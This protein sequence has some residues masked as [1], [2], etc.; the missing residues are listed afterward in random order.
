MS[1]IPEDKIFPRAKWSLFN[2]SKP[3][4]KQDEQELI[5]LWEKGMSLDHCAIKLGRTRLAIVCRLQLLPIVSAGHLI[6]NNAS[7]W[8][9]LNS[10]RPLFI[11]EINN[12]I[13]VPNPSQPIKEET[14]M[15]KFTEIAN[16][17][18]EI[19]TI[20]KALTLSDFVVEIAALESKISALQTLQ[21]KPK[22]VVQKLKNLQKEIEELVKQCDSLI[23]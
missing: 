14:E 1:S 17:K 9:N 3:W 12:V 19:N 23:P 6:S 21:N 10:L 5:R 18:N 16:L 20:T 4:S 8:K 11:D 2:Q 22:A 7:T 13:N 15:S